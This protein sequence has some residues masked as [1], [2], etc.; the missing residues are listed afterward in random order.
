MVTAGVFRV[1][2][3]S[4][5]FETSDFAMLVVTGFGR[6]YVLRKWGVLTPYR[7]PAVVVRDLVILGGQA[8]IDRTFSGIGGRVRGWRAARPRH[9]YPAAIAARGGASPYFRNLQRR[10]QRRRKLSAPG[11]G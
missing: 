7:L 4:P 5:M 9:A 11:P 6:G 3:L 2:R 1:A 8:A 10:L